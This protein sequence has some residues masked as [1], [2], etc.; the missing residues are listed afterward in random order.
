VGDVV[1]RIA[2]GNA[3]I[4]GRIPFRFRQRLV[5]A[6]VATAPKRK[7]LRLAVIGPNKRFRGE[8]RF[9][10]CTVP[11]VSHFFRVTHGPSIGRFAGCVHVRMACVGGC[12]GRSAGD[13][14]GES[15]VADGAD[16]SRVSDADIFPIPIL[17]DGQP[18]FEADMGIARG[19]RET[20]DPA[21]RG[22]NLQTSGS[23][24]ASAGGGHVEIWR[25]VDRPRQG[26]RYILYTER[27]QTITR[28]LRG[29]LRHEQP[30]G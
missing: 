22:R 26:D 28:L 8:G 29:H 10:D 30:P 24:E 12:D 6:L 16:E 11:P 5:A 21:E 13:F 18:N 15:G 14:A 20:S 23:A 9:M 2:R 27:R 4:V 3:V 25:R 17:G 7:S 19:G 1:G